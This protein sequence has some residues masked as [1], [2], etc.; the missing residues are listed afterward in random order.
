MTTQLSQDNDRVYDEIWNL[1]NAHFMYRERLHNWVYWRHKFDGQ[2]KT[3][4]SALIAINSM[5]DSLSD[6]Y[7]FL[8][9]E[10]S[11]EERK[12]L[13]QKT[14]VV[15][16]RMLEGQIGYIHIST[17]NSMFCVQETAR[18]L[19]ELNGAHGLILDLRDNWGGS[20]N[21]TFDVFSLLTKSGKFVTMRG[22][23]DNLDYFEEMSLT[24]TAAVSIENGVVIKNARISNLAGQK[25]IVVLVDGN[26]KSAAEMLAGALRDNGR[27]TIMG[28]RTYGKG[29]VQRVW[30]FPNNTSIKISS[31]RYYLPAGASIHHVGLVP[32]FFVG[33]EIAKVK[34]GNQNSTRSASNR[35][36]I[37]SGRIAVLSTTQTEKIAHGEHLPG[38]KGTT[39][40]P[41]RDC[42]LDEAQLVL[43]RKLV[44]LAKP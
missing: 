17:F 24:D 2:M 35:S 31:A 40:N 10:A 3:K 41:W 42:I 23:T 7:T 4:N 18:A 29:I 21:A 39:K 11:T 12:A 28:C 38:E 5:I 15:D 26:T 44:S 8:R 13:R 20:I 6:E 9:D 32:D 19:I 37:S 33:T 36:E 34:S 43:K 14:R 22:T 16:H 1:I 25:P 27:A 30:E